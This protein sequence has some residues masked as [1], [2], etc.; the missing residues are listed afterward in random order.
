MLKNTSREEEME[1]SPVT[2]PSHKYVTGFYCV[3]INDSH[4]IIDPRLVG[5]DCYYKK[6]HCNSSDGVNCKIANRYI[7]YF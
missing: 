5:V 4:T 1:N 7:L 2:T 3:C 6:V